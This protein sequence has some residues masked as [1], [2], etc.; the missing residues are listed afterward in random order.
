MGYANIEELVLILRSDIG[1]IEQMTHENPSR[2]MSKNKDKIVQKFNI[3]SERDKQTVKERTNK[4]SKQLAT[5]CEEQ[6]K[7]FQKSDKFLNK[8]DKFQ[9]KLRG[10]SMKV[11]KI[12]PSKKMLK[13][14]HRKKAYRKLIETNL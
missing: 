5:V 7:Q 6:Q 12:G 8:P 11:D 3:N 4:V 2:E 14:V 1:M 10:T 9:P 13:L